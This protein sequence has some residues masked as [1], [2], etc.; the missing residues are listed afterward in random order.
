MKN[1][2]PLAGEKAPPPEL[3][4]SDML[5]DVSL[6]ERRPGDACSMTSV[7]LQEGVELL[8]WR[9]R[10]AQPTE[11]ALL[12]DSDR[13]HFSYMLQGRASC[14]VRSGCR[15]QCWEARE[16]AGIIHF[17]PG[18]SGVSRQQG[19]YTGVSVMMRPDVFAAWGDAASAELRRA[20]RDGWCFAGN[21]SGAE[22]HATARQLHDALTENAER[23]RM[24][25]KGQGLALCGLLLESQSAPAAGI[26]SGDRKKLMHARDLLLADL[27]QAPSLSELGAASGLS[28]LKLKRGFRALF[29]NS[30][31]GLFLQERMFEARRR[32][33]GGG[34]SV[35]EIATDLGYTNVSH[36]AAAFRKQFGVNPAMFK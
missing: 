35:T 7:A 14:E 29:G 1:R 17:G 4:V 3:L 20:I 33:S 34:G 16:A 6:L 9:C 5:A 32:L 15:C 36:F 11:L 10:F 24:W 8:V 19:G 2:M 12:D 18:R 25:L 28:L 26:G 22:L 23:N 21:C 13:I 31:Y 30:V 27:C